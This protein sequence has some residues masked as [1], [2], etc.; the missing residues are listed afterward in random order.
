MSAA[1]DRL[2]R[3]DERPP[4]WLGEA[5]WDRLNRIELQHQRAQ[6]QHETL[7][8]GLDAMHGDLFDAWRRYCD[9]IAELDRTTAELEAL[10]TRPE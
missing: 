5:F 9:V 3:V 6:C 8:R 4:F 1:E 7:R 2:G 10:R